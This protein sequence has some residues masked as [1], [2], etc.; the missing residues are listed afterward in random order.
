MNAQ[1][2]IVQKLKAL[3][4]ELQ[5]HYKVRELGLFGSFVR[6]EQ[7][8]ASDIDILVDFTDDASFFDLVRL[9]DFLEEQLQRRVDIVT[10]DSLRVELRES[11]LRETVAI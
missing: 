3:K 2:E 6:G 8:E 1:E 10:K 11:V 4:S 5:A 9:A 7:H